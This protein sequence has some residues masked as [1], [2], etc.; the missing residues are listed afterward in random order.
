MRINLACIL[1]ILIIFPM[2]SMG[3]WGDSNSDSSTDN[4]TGSLWDSIK[5]FTGKTIEET[6]KLSS[7]VIEQVQELSSETKELVSKSLK[8]SI[9]DFQ[10]Y[11][12]V[13][14]EAG[15]KYSGLTVNIGLFPGPDFYFVREFRLT[16]EQQTALIEKYKDETIASF[17]LKTIFNAPEVLFL[18]DHIVEE[19]TMA[20]VNIPPKLSLTLI[21]IENMDIEKQK[22]HLLYHRKK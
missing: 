3:W 12:G 8:D 9:D 15:F 19:V 11:K 4:S 16:E 7:K 22:D 21:P 20:L 18:P 10:H 17:L 6:D 1:T 5:E 13:M 14:K 2:Q